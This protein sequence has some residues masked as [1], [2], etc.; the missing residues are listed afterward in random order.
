MELPFPKKIFVSHTATRPGLTANGQH[1]GS[2][3]MP[4]G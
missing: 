4:G 3:N 1:Y 2:R